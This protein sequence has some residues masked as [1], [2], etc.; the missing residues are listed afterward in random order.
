VS[1]VVGI[2]KPRIVKPAVIEKPEPDD[3]QPPVDDEVQSDETTAKAVR[4][5]KKPAYVSPYRKTV[6][7]TPQQRPKSTPSMLPSRTTLKSKSVS[8]SPP[9]KNQTI[10]AKTHVFVNKSNYLKK[11]MNGRPPAQ[12]STPAKPKNG[13]S[14]TEKNTK[15]LNGRPKSAGNAAQLEPVAPQRQ[16]TFIKE[17]PSHP[18]LPVVVSAPPTPSKSRLPSKI[19]ASKTSASPQPSTPTSSKPGFVSK[20]RIPLQK[21]ISTTDAKRAT[22]PTSATKARNFSVYKSP[23][24][25]SVPLS[26]RSNSNSSIKSTAKQRLS[27]APGRSNTTI[28]PTT[29]PASESPTPPPPKKDITSRI[30]SIWKKID[31]SKKKQDQQKKDN[32]VWIG[33]NG[34]HESTAT[35]PP[36]A[37]LIRSSTFDSS[38]PATACETPAAVAMRKTKDN[39]VNGN[40]LKRISRLGS[41][42]NVEGEF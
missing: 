19:P 14:V 13:M 6:T 42:V 28:A 9:A 29:K 4:G 30:S 5:R 24:V 33:K 18:Q 1:D 40:E 35:P 41:F 31:E 8:P 3:T 21:S 20:L 23:S 11:G 10:I 37:P 16:G 17:E 26:Q 12:A 38:P 27:V 36:P 22:T 32:R 25:P 15:N 34:V 7:S 2:V 39:L